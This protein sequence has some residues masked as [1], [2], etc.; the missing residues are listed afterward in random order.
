MRPFLIILG[1]AAA[2]CIGHRAH[3]QISPS[4]YDF[5][6]PTL[7]WYTIET[8]HFNIVFHADGEGTGSSR[9]AQAV[10]RIAEEI[11]GPITELYEYRPPRTTI[12]LKDYED[13]S[14][15]A[16]YFFDNKIEIWAP[17]LN[18]PLRGDHDWLRNVITHEFTHIVQVQATVKGSRRLPFVYFQYLDYENVRRPDVLY[19]YPNVIVTYPVASLNNPAWF[20]E[21]TAQY[22]RA[23][24]DYDRWDSHRDMLLRSRFLAGMELS[25]TEMGGFFSLTGHERETVYNQG[26]AFST[27]LAETYGEHVLRDISQSLSRRGTFRVERAIRAATGTSG[28]DVFRNW[29]EQLRR[30]YSQ[31]IAGLG[32]ETVAGH[33]IEEAG[34]S[35]MYPRLSP[36]GGR[37]AFV[38]NRGED[39][40]LSALV[41][42]DLESGTSMAHHIRDEAGETLAHTCAFGHTI[43]RGVS[44]AISWHPD[45][46]RIAYSR[47]LVTPEGYRYAD[48]FEL[49]VESGNVDRLTRRARAFAPSYSSDGS[50]LAFAG[51]R[52]GSS[53]I[54]VRDAA[55][56]AIRNLTQLM[57]GRQAYDPVWH[58]TGEWIYFSLSDQHGRSLY[59]V[60]SA[61]GDLEAVLEVD[62]D[63]RFPAFGP[64]GD[65]LYF[66]AD[67]NGIFNLYVAA[68]DAPSTFRP[69][70]NV[71]GGAFMPS[72]GADGSIV[73]AAYVWDGYK[74]ARLAATERFDGDALPAYTPP[75]MFDAK[76]GGDQV[77]PMLAHVDRDI[78]PLDA[79]VIR[80]VRIEGRHPLPSTSVEEE[81]AGP[82]RQVKKYDDIFTTFNVFPVL[83]LD[84]YVERRRSRVEARLPDRSRT[85]TLQRNTK[86]GMYVSSREVNEELSLF[87]GMLVSPFSRNYGSPASFFAPSR[88][89]ELERDAF[90]QFDY[91]KGLGFIPK[92][93]SPQLSLE[94]FNIRR[95]VENGLSIEEF[96]CT[97]CYPDTT[98]A[99]LSYN[100]WEAGLYARSKITPALLVEA[101]Y[102]YSPYRV[103]TERFFSKEF[104]QTIDASSSRYFIGR[105]ARFAA[106]FEM[107]RPHRNSDVV[108]EGMRASLAYE[109]EL[110]QLLDRFDVEDGYLVPTYERTTIHRLT[111]DARWASRLPGSPLGGSHGVSVRSRMSG[112]I[113]DP[114]DS[115]YNDYVGGLIGARG[116]PFY[117]LGGNQTAWLQASYHFPIF[118]AIR[119]QVLF[120]YID[121]LYGRLF[122]DAAAS[123]TGAFPGADH[124]RRDAGAELRLS[125]GSFYLLPTAVFTSATY[126]FDAFDV[127][128][129]DGFL[130]PDGSSSVRYGGEWQWHFGVLFDFDL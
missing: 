80:S 128:L 86:V 32:A 76:R 43:R 40:S 44:G 115:F 2:L 74:I 50:R 34:S 7:D 119:E 57:D 97:S 38:S 92:R 99:N 25:L 10:A 60:S 127:Q 62:G 30:E 19:G 51:E 8:E 33:L 42:K 78:R 5:A 95:N 13:Y 9:T 69:V 87:G 121:K 93:W 68:T 11:Y 65:S 90:F 83:R 63:V 107:N 66:S 116:Y 31:G 26:F 35:N 112:V 27:F 122:V 79:E 58:P 82:D 15:G 1:L 105:A 91:G 12:I 16:A 37:V 106:Y 36:D 125:L 72:I 18:T 28:A 20:A 104:A 59:R 108:P 81:E 77:R 130:T 126:G 61:G 23:S 84:N 88:L 98:L 89:L 39:Y 123:W 114:V 111:F 94:V 103:T 3:A 52:D 75:A 47:T 56:G 118:P 49:H 21:G 124:I 129:D 67:I 70:T 110:G 48:I 55:G 45:G 117:A 54:F 4:H 53:N 24:L 102:R 120:A 64:Q 71:V 113:G 101:G 29:A 17:A 73:Y 46:E 96:P 85:E 41:V 100:L 109:R 22:Q 14:N 6:R